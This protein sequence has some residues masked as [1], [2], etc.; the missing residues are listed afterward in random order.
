MSY[1]ESSHLLMLST[2][3]KQSTIK[4]LSMMDHEKINNDLIEAV[5]EW[6]VDGQH[7]VLLHCCSSVWRADPSVGRIEHKGNFK[8]ELS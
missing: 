7:Q 2:D 6:I 1:F 5:L 3:Y 8:Q 4:N